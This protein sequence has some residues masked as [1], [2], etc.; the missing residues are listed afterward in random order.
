M[1]CTPENIH[2]Q[3]ELLRLH[4]KN[5]YDFYRQALVYGGVDFA[6]AMTQRGLKESCASIASCK[7]IL[8]SWGLS[9][10][11]NPEDN[12][13][14]PNNT[15]STQNNNF[16]NI[17]SNQGG[18]GSF[19]GPVNFNYIYG[20]PP[21]ETSEDL[22][23]SYRRE[24]AYR[25]AQWRD[26]YAA[27]W[28]RAELSSAPQRD[29]GYEPEDRFFSTSY[30]TISAKA[31]NRRQD[32]IPFTDLRGGLDRCGDM[33]LLGPPGSGKTTA[34]WRLALDLAEEGL[35]RDPQAPLPV[36]VRLSRLTPEQDLLKHIQSELA[37]ATLKDQDNH[38]I[39]L[40]KHRALAPLLPRLLQEGRL[41]LLWDG[42]NETPP[43][44]FAQTAR[45]IAQLRRRYPGP[46]GGP[47]NQHLITCRSDDYD[48][49]SAE[50]SIELSLNRAMIQP[51]DTATVRQI[52]LT[53]LGDELGGKLLEALT[54][55][56]QRTLYKLAHTP[57][58]LR[59]LCTVYNETQI[60]PSTRAQLLEQF[61]QKRI[62]WEQDWQREHDDQQEKVVRF[63]QY[64]LAWPLARLAYAMTE[65]RWY[66]T[67]VSWEWA[68]QELAAAG[69][70]LPPDQVRALALSADLLEPLAGEREIGFSHQ[71]IQEYFAAMALREEL[72]RLE[73]HDGLSSGGSHDPLE[74][75]A[76]PGRRT[77]WEEALLLLA[78]LYGEGTIAPALVRRFLAFPLDAARL[79]L[80]SGDADPA[81]L[82]ELR[83]RALAQLGDPHE[84]VQTRLTAARALALAGDPRFPVTL[85]QWRGA[86]EKGSPDDR[87]SYFH[88][89]APGDYWLGTDEPGC[90]DDQPQQ[91]VTFDAPLWIARLP[92]TKAQWR[93]WAESDG[94]A[95]DPTD[96]MGA[97]D[98][99]EPVIG[100]SWTQVQAFCRWLGTQL[101]VAVRLPT[102]HE[103]EAAAAGPEGRR[104]PWGDSWIRDRAAT[105]ENRD[106]R[107]HGE[108]MPV[109]CFP[110]GASPCGAL[111]MAGN[112][113]EWTVERPAAQPGRDRPALR[114]GNY[115]S[116]KHDVR[117]AARNT[118]DQPD[119]WTHAGF[120]IVVELTA[121]EA[122]VRTS[123]QSIP[124]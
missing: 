95:P 33:I 17:N 102:E 14:T 37:Q 64:D 99:N 59:L 114:G 73:R 105:L 27:V 15:P 3:Q 60:L 121:E 108:S 28:L 16:H 19:L 78:G 1:Q 56:H 29:L 69:T 107:G 62:Q 22:L 111:D 70:A 25:C 79:L 94:G 118:V 57:L 117:C 44:I 88:R 120:R 119:E 58:L 91:R 77:G 92:I 2:K 9:I 66:G 43:E 104:Y 10:H 48:L 86:L 18:Q 5:A 50:H 97:D 54:A 24:I 72:T 41:V 63:S 89:V 34:L 32:T 109:G 26:R 35:K 51:L 90:A 49:L 106:T 13:F 93:A 100:A 68:K 38:P 71:L 87:D 7:A 11:D 31:P 21:E 74:R 81:L 123:T 82:D 4:R 67:S 53:R 112:V 103:W 98:A 85:E 40:P 113:W 101:G 61:V 47:T 8:R 115:R 12:V 80:A 30:H 76:A 84:P 124:L 6:P 42:L 65:N 83:D 110:A 122:E 23:T 36:F 45:Q 116:P 39:E 52:V 96:S 20:S 46:P 55:P 75:Y